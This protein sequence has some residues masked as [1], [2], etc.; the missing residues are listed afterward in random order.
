VVFTWT[1][2]LDS[3][4][5]HGSPPYTFPPSYNNAFRSLPIL[6][7]NN[8]AALRY[9]CPFCRFQRRLLGEPGLARV[10][11]LVAEYRLMIGRLGSSKPD[12]VHS[13]PPSRAAP[14]GPLFNPPKPTYEYGVFPPHF[15]PPA[16]TV[17]YNPEYPNCDR[18]QLQ[19]VCKLPRGYLRYL[20][21]GTSPPFYGLFGSKSRLRFSGS[22]PS[23][24][25][26]ARASPLIEMAGSGILGSATPSY[27][28]ACTAQDSVWH[29]FARSLTD[30]RQFAHRSS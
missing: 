1:G 4:S 21:W 17:I 20:R 19:A 14:F 30:Q 16:G 23:R 26:E 6:R 24:R 2:T 9:S 27:F 5:V 3:H 11:D 18:A 8:G 10:L 25:W 22:S 29:P 15:D 28:S 12:L 13:S 7:D